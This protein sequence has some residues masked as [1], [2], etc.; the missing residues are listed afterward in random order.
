MEDSHNQSKSENTNH[1]QNQLVSTIKTGTITV[2]SGLLTALSTTGS[3]F[4]NILAKKP[5]DVMTQMQEYDTKLIDGSL[6]NRLTHADQYLAK[7]YQFEH[8]TQKQ[9]DT[10]V[11]ETKEVESKYENNMRMIQSKIDS[12]KTELINFHTKTGSLIQKMSTSRDNEAVLDCMSKLFDFTEDLRAKVGGQRIFEHIDLQGVQSTTD[13]LKAI[14]LNKSIL[15]EIAQK[16]EAELPHQKTL[17]EIKSRIV[18]VKEEIALIKK[19][20]IDH[21]KVLS[22]GTGPHVHQEA[23]PLL[24][25][26]DTNRTDL[27][28]TNYTN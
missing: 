21:T 7:L 28:K 6:S 18:R 17:K 5:D 8:S 2:A 9:Y 3:Y 16:R 27:T 22:N 23:M 19:F 26:N 12:I 25:Q 24:D 10:A 13:Y 11:L 20:K 15:N 4:G 14:E 1:N